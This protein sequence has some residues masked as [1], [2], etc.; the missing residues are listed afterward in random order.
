MHF[1]DWPLPKPWNPTLK[2]DIEKVQP[3]CADK[4]DGTK[5]CSSREGWLEIYQDFRDRREKVCSDE[6][7]KPIVVTI[8]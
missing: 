7:F 4:E 6:F 5:D 3:A 1:S 8:E 2:S